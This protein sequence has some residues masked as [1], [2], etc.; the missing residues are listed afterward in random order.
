MAMLSIN[1]R[2]V[3]PPSEMK[4]AIFEPG[5]GAA[6]NAAGNAVLDRMGAKR[7]LHLK[8]AHMEGAQLAALLETVGTGFFEVS[9]PDPEDG[10]M[11]TITCMCS[12]RTAGMLRMEGG[13]PVWTG[14]EMTWTE[15]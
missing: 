5:N 7:R 2:A 6:R 13:L 12:E 11:R 8:W 9:C 4:V 10:E 1:G 3:L 14:I 15:R